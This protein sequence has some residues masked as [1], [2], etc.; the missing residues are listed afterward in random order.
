MARS[1]PSRTIEAWNAGRKKSERIA[2]VT[3]L[4]TKIGTR[5]HVMPFVRMVRLVT[6]MF[7]APTPLAMVNRMMAT[8]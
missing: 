1:V 8:R 6:M 7:T 4:H 3:T 2:A 5:D